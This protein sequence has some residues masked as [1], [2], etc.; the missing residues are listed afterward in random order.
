M[1]SEHL[2]RKPARFD[3]EQWAQ[4]HAPLELRFGP[5]FE[6]V[7]RHEDRVGALAPDTGWFLDR[8]ERR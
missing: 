5:Y 3:F 2:R 6:A 1:L 4:T 7:R 8:W